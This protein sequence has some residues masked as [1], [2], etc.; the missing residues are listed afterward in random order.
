[1]EDAENTCS[2]GVQ[3]VEWVSHYKIARPTGGLNSVVHTRELGGAFVGI[4]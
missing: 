1:M 4:D 3:D 2:L